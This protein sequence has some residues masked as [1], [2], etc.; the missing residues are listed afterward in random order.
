MSSSEFK[1]GG[2]HV[3]GQV[4]GTTL[5]YD[6]ADAIVPCDLER[7]VA[8]VTCRRCRRE[9]T[10]AGGTVIAVVKIAQNEQERVVHS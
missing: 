7:G 2:G 4:R 10:F 3:L 9:R 1:C 5:R 8:V 6:P